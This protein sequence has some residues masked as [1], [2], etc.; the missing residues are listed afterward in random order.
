VPNPTECL[1]VTRRLDSVRGHQHH[2]GRSETNE[3]GPQQCPYPFQVQSTTEG[4]LLNALLL[5]S[6]SADAAV[7][8][9]GVAKTL[10][11][12]RSCR[13]PWHPTYLSVKASTRKTPQPSPTTLSEFQSVQSPVGTTQRPATLRRYCLIRDRHRRVI[14]RAFDR[15]EGMKRVASD[16]AEEAQDDDGNLLKNEGGTYYTSFVDDCSDR[17]AGVGMLSTYHFAPI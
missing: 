2:S 3:E 1:P 9:Y 13:N 4:N 14:S 5:H 17:N 6:A 15:A 12:S 10:F 7:Y 16:G 8:L 11:D